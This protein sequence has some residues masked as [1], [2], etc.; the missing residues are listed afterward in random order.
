[1]FGSAHLVL[2][3]PCFR[4]TARL[5]SQD[6][7]TALHAASSKGY[8]EVVDRLIAAGAEVDSVTEVEPCTRHAVQSHRPSLQHGP[9]LLLATITDLATGAL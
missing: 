5:S 2:I 4:P 9:A 6:G 7:T 1:V 3:I 8:L